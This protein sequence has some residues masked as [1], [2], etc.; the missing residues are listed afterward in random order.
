MANKKIILIDQDGPLANFV[1]G[2][3]SELRKKFPNLPVQEIEKYEIYDN[4]PEH[5]KEEIETIY[6]APGFFANLKPTTGSLPAVKKLIN[7]GH[8]IFICTSPLSKYENCV[9]EKY[10]WVE[11]YLGRDFTKK[12]ILTKDKT[13]IKGDALIDDRPDIRG[14]INQPEW[15]HV[16]FDAPYNKHV[17]DR[18]RINK[19]W[20]NWQEIINDLR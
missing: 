19:D 20:S 4:Y 18:I 14:Q 17:A 1:D 9:R 7:D 16:L 15:L 2:F 13:L 3:L 11:K 10:E 6:H 5:L 12:I 8:Q